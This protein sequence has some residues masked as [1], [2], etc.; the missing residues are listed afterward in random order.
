MLSATL[1]KEDFMVTVV[2]IP[3]RAPATN[4]IEPLIYQSLT[5]DMI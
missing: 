2:I 3:N 1:V 4:F 5:S